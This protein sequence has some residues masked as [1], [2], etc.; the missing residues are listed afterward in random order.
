MFT[1]PFTFF[2][3]FPAGQS[4]A[5]VGNSGA[6]ASWC[7][8]G[9][10]EQ[11]DVVVR[12]NE[13]RVRDFAAQV[14]KRTDLLVTNPYVEGRARTIGVEI[15][16][17]MALVIFSHQRRGSRKLLLDW[18]NQTPAFTTFAPR[19]HKVP[20]VPPGLSISTGT[21]GIYLVS[22]LLQPSRMLITGFS[23]FNSRYA[24]YY[25]SRESPPGVSK[26]DFPRE[27]W[28]FVRLLN[29]LNHR[30]EITPE[31]AEIFVTTQVSMGGHI[32]VVTPEAASE[33]PLR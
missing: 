4:I 15:Q 2:E 13:C 12:F 27:A 21:Y 5:V 7:M 6:L 23:M 26:H 3:T 14:G 8:G 33:G 28:V 32:R 25:W 9:E 19:L 16:P 20:D 31:V 18:L 22:R 24:P 11:R 29:T 30:L 1:D 10:I 17:K